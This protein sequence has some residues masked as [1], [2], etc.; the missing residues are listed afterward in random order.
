MPIPLAAAITAVVF[1]AITGTILGRS[2]LE[3]RALQTC[4]GL[5]AVVG[6][7]TWLIG[8]DPGTEPAM[9]A[10]AMTL[11]GLAVLGGVLA[12]RGGPPAGDRG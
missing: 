7:A 3:R 2:K 10:G 9:A 1:G 11:G 4:A 5:I 12:A 6:A 8:P